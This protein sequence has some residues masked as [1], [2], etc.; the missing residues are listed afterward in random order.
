VPVVQDSQSLNEKP[1]NL[2]FPEKERNF[3][4]LMLGSVNFAVR[5]TRTEFFDTEAEN[6][7]DRALFLQNS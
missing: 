3:V 5:Q 4:W 6:P 2:V 1:N 7:N